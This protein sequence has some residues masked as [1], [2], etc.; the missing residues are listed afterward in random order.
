M[1]ATLQNFLRKTFDLRE[2]EIV[3]ALLMQL[4]I[5]FIITTLLIVKPTVTGLFL[6]EIGV[7]QLPRV[8]ILVSIFAGVISTLYAQFIG[9][10]PLYRLI[11]FTLGVSV[12]LFSLFG[13]LLSLNA[14]GG[15]VLY[16]FYIWVAI[17]GVLT[18]SQFWILANVVFNVREAKRLFGFIGT[19]AIAGGIFGGYLTNL[20]AE[21]I[22][23]ERLLFVGAG[24]L[25]LCI[26]ITIYIWKKQVLPTQ[27]RFQRKKKIGKRDHAFQIIRK[28]RHLS[29]MAGIVGVSVIIAKLV[30]YQFNAVASEKISDPDELTAFLGFWFS[31]FNL[32]SLV[33]QLLLTRRVVGTFGVGT[34]LLF[35]PVSILFGA[36]ILFFLPELWVAIILKTSDGSLKQSINKAAVELLALPIP[37]E[38]KAQTKTFIDV[39]IDSVATGIG[40]LIL[41]FL[42]KGLG[43]AVPFISLMIASLIVVWIFFVIK[44]RRE[45]LHS[46]RLSFLQ[47]SSP[48]AEEEI[49]ADQGS[50]LEGWKKVLANGNE[51]QLLYALKKI[52]EKPD[53]RLFEQVVPLI[54]HS[55]ELV[56]ASA[57]ELLYFFRRPVDVKII[58]E[59]TSD[60]SQKVKIAAFEYLFEHDPDRLDEMMGK[61]LQEADYKIQSAALVSLAIESR[62]NPGLRTTFDL[63]ERLHNAYAR[64]S[65]MKD[66]GKKDFLKIGLLKALGAAKL[67]AFFPVIEVYFQDPNKRVVQQA[68]LSAGNTLH[69]YFIPQLVEF[70]DD[71]KK[72]QHAQ[73]A[74]GNYGDEIVPLLIKYVDE[75]STSTEIIRSFPEILEKFGRQDAVECLFNLLQNGDYNL[76]LVS[77]RSLNKMRTAFPYLQFNDQRTIKFILEEAK[78][79]EGLLAVLYAQVKNDTTTD[80]PEELLPFDQFRADLIQLLESRLDINLERIFRLL[81]LKYPPE[82]ILPVYERINSDKRDLRTNALEYLDN[83]L[84]ISL[85]KILMPI[86]ETALLDTISEEA[87]QN[88]GFKVP[89]ELKGFERVMQSKDTQL[90]VAILHLIKA[91]FKPVYRP[92]IRKAAED[93]HPKVR[94]LARALIKA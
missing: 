73:A 53:D 27:T 26:P 50:V 52:K 13:I 44:V 57:L 81:G 39:F 66:G 16:A 48:S 15:W 43:L 90:K 5:F 72:R 82:D 20:L 87:I 64:I 23:S 88:L 55:S 86:I 49:I 58:E 78:L 46:F 60:D 54:H 4:N 92:L 77:L 67:P 29:Y 70:L 3:R 68:V 6:S 45:Y 35:L 33:I 65:D 31:N 1:R 7:E 12:L 63:E 91:Q 42:V 34:S 2:G 85:K 38:K 71:E 18:A 80:K 56:R 47:A 40:G 11:I 8:F 61:F 89:D 51:Q 19:G 94:K 36:T 17:F 59:L 30:D 10:F 79:Y 75:P 24:I 93:A 69:A 21:S 41:I 25:F 62:D 32:I 83:L 76:R 74:L 37:S 14:I 28:S 84:E 22:G 9:R